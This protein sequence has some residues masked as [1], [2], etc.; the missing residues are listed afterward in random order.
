MSA[1]ALRNACKMP[2]ESSARLHLLGRSGEPLMCERG[3]NIL[4]ALHEWGG[5]ETEGLADWNSAARLG[6]G[7]LGPRGT[8]ARVWK[9]IGPRRCRGQD[10]RSLA[11]QVS[12]GNHPRV[13]S[14]DDGGRMQVQNAPFSRRGKT[15]RA[16]TS[17]VIRRPTRPISQG[18]A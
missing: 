12:G 9:H 5:V 11:F 4:K 17:H 18:L 13:L 1:Y 3:A 7:P 16:T 10:A 14:L 15:P 2:A 8:G 6:L